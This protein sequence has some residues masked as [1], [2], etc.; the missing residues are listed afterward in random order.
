MP[1]GFI[2]L[3]KPLFYFLK[4]VLSHWIKVIFFLSSYSHFSDGLFFL[5][6]EKQREFYKNAK[7]V[8][9]YKKTVKQRNEPDE[10]HLRGALAN[11]VFIF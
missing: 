3:Q 10:M 2:R 8:K 1:S 9:K 6:P 5:S 11:E 7:I 4:V